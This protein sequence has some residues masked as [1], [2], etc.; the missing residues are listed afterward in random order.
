M[1]GCFDE[2]CLCHRGNLELKE[3]WDRWERKENVALEET[4]DLWDLL[5]LLENQ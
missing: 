5:D 3:S 4:R 1:G 2:A